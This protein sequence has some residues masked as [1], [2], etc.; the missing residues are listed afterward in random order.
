MDSLKRIKRRKQWY[1]R[2]VRGE[3]MLREREGVE[4]FVVNT[5]KVREETVGTCFVKTNPCCYHSI[6]S[7]HK[8][9]KVNNHKPT[10]TTQPLNSTPFDI[11]HTCV[12]FIQS[13]LI[14]NT[15]QQ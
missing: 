15:P 5:N 7:K 6:H 13:T 12:L 11:L 3:G 1:Q 10:S 14:T 4:W 9:K 2:R 8:Q